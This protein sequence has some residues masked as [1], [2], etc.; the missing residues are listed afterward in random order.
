M[1][2]MRNQRASI[3]ALTAVLL[4][5]TLIAQST[6]EERLDGRRP[7]ILDVSLH[8]GGKLIGV[9]V[10]KAGKPVQGNRIQIRQQSKVIASVDTDD[11][12]R[13][14]AAGL[15]G[16]VYEISTAQ[17]VGM[18]RL[19]TAK[20]APPAA[21]QSVLLVANEN[22]VRGQF[23]FDYDD[24]YD[25]DPGFTL[26]DPYSPGFQAASLALGAGGLA[27]GIIGITQANKGSP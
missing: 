21:R 13:F 5:L 27:T 8:E 23:D 2:S 19:W 15:R 4:G 11:R 10:N 26:F 20:T 18:F 3:T 17:G 6:A 14:E 25:D 1:V 12:G 22:V 7:S 9:Y 24:D 16:G